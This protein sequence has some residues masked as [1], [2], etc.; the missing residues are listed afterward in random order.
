MIYG[1]ISLYRKGKLVVFE[2]EWGKILGDVYREYVVPI[3]YAYKREVE[4]YTGRGNVI[5]ME[6][7][8]P[9]HTANATKA[10]SLNP[11]TLARRL[12]I[13]ADQSDQ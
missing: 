6:D 4:Q 10:L 9:S 12:S 13:R 5:L 8:A 7:G 3:I 2:K 11:S 1:T